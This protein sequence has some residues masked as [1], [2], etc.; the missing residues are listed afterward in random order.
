MRNALTWLKNGML[1]IFKNNKTSDE[2]SLVRVVDYS[3]EQ[4][5]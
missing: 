4:I 1:K 2:F 3:M 5:V